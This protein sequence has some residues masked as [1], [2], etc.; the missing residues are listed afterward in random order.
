MHDLYEKLARD[1]EAMA[2]AMHGGEQSV[3]P[4]CIRAYSHMH[5]CGY[6]VMRLCGYASC[7]LLR[8][9]PFCHPSGFFSGG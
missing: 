4:C 1:I 2:T 7:T 8:G 5:K 9:R 3:V 6:P